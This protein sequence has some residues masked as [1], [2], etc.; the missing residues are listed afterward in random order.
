MELKE[1]DKKALGFLGV[2][3]VGGLIWM[4]VVPMYDEHKKRE[5]QISTLV[6]ELRTAHKKAENMS[7]LAGEV[8]LLKYRLAELKKVLPTEAGSFELIAK[9]QELAARAGVRIK[10]IQPE[11]SRDRGEGWKA[12]ILRIQFTCYWFQLVE[13]LW[14]IENYERLIDISSINISPDPLAPGTKLQSFTI[15]IIANVYS[16]TLTEV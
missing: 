13:F 9:M 3:A 2:A 15:S 11:E 12:E 6:K 10:G 14:R 16:S 5:E 1:S 7:E 8:D 4:F